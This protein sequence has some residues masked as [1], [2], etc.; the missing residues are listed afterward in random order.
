VFDQQDMFDQKLLLQLLQLLQP[1]VMRSKGVFRVAQR[2]WV[3]PQFLVSPPLQQQ[4]QQQQHGDESPGQ[5]EQQQQ[6][7]A[8]CADST[9]GP[10]EGLQL[11]PVCY[12]GPSMVEVIV[13]AAPISATDATGD[14]ATAVASPV[15][16]TV[17]DFLQQQKEQSGA[18]VGSSNSSSTADE[19]AA[20]QAGVGRLNLKGAG[21]K[22]LDSTWQLIEEALLACLQPTK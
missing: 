5:T 21:T 2:Q 8:S 12:R 6:Q 3:M 4:Q 13:S 22:S 16:R 18:A 9:A 15:S 20:A 17:A 7:T 11:Q 19:A 10:K 1:H 14:A